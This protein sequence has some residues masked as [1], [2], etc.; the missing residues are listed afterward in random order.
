MRDVRAT[1]RIAILGTGGRGAEA[2]GRWF[3][4]HPDRSQ[5]VAVAE[6]V[7]G[8][9]DRFADRAGVPAENRFAHWEDLLRDTHRLRLDAVVVALPDNDHLEPTVAATRLGLAVLLEKPMAPDEATLR[10]M[11]SR[12]SGLDHRIAVA[13]VLR[14]TPFWRSV[15]QVV[16]SGAV[17]DLVTI[18]IEENIGFWHF[19]HS[20]VR[21][22]W[23]STPS[24]SPMVLAKTSHDL[25]LIRWLAGSAP[26]RVSSVGSL[27]HFHEGNAP[28]GA[29]T[30]CVKGCPVADTCPFFAP[31]YYVDAL[32]HVD[33]WPVALLGDDVSPEG[34]M[35]ALEHGP[36]GRCV[37]RSD[38]DVVDHQQTIFQFPGGLTASLTTSAFTGSN[39]R[40]FQITG[41]RG[42]LSGQ[43]Q[44]GDL[45]L[46]TFTPGPHHLPDTAAGATQS[47][48]GPLDHAVYQWRAVPPRSDDGD[49]RGHAGGDDALSERFVEGV[50]S[51]DFDAHVTT[52][53]ATSLDSHWMAFAAERSRLASTVLELAD[54]RG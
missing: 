38:N 9:Y 42:E 20:Y 23:A 45:R 22:N 43:M 46:E 52:T 32:A 16:A 18:R 28:D 26:Q 48:N 31:R 1:V 7:T 8:R 27:L 25:D 39:T 50:A 36:Y 37:Y 4:E 5:V 19:A 41:T 15:H 3:V 54:V 53:F 11:E 12:L 13:H 29:P 34:R 2:Y 17:G 35:A 33:S 40:T 49:H 44:T 24:S 47:V 51:G 10:E 30:H 14:E 6:P 21:G